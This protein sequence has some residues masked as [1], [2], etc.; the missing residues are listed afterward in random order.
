MRTQLIV[1]VLLV[2]PF[3]SHA[4]TGLLANVGWYR[5]I[6]V[7]FDPWY[8]DAAYQS[9]CWFAMGVGLT[10]LG[11]SFVTALREHSPPAGSAERPK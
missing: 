9:W 6:G 1:G 7:D 5:S 3:A 11:R 8:A 4:V 2:A 10:L